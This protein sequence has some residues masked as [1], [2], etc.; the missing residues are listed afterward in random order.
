MFLI[1]EYLLSFKKKIIIP[2]I[3]NNELEHYYYNKF[4]MLKNNKW[5]I[6]EPVNAELYFNLNLIDVVFV[7]LII[8]DKKGHRI[9]YGKGYY[10][11]FL[12]K[13]DKNTIKIGISFFQCIKK[14]PINNY[15]IALDYL[16]YPNGILDFNYLNKL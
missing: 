3:K 10:D 9:G 1:I 6:L 13:L 11:R 16:I 7:P 5:N 4:T 14:I 2:K 8:C 12:S 15:D